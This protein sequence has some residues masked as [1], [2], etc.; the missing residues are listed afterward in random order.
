MSRNLF[1]LARPLA[2]ALALA[3]TSAPTPALA[4]EE[5]PAPVEGE[6]SGR[7]LDGYFATGALV[8]LALFIICKSARRS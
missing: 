3:A 8:G 5:A 6:G 1:R 7:S 4:Q 2:L